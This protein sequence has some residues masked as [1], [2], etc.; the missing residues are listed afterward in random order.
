MIIEVSR[1][2]LMIHVC[3]LQDRLMT[4]VEGFYQEDISEE[5]GGKKSLPVCHVVVS[6]EG[7]VSKCT[8]NLTSVVLCRATRL[9]SM[10]FPTEV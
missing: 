3:A 7:S 4:T 1:V 9:P 5:G 2:F 10:P 6:P 8:C